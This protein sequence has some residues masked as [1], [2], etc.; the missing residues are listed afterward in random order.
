MPYKNLVSDVLA[1]HADQIL[2]NQ[3][4]GEN[5]TRLF[6]D[7]ENLPPLLNLAEQVKETL[8]PVSP[9]DDFKEQLQRDLMAAAYLQQ[10]QAKQ[11]NEATEA[12]LLLPLL[13]S[14][15]IA[16]MGLLFLRRRQQSAV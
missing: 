5:Y 6:P 4:Y 7:D 11:Q 15:V 16:L 10:A 13:F 3:N 8:Q 9:P 14:A 2:K 1:A 12:S